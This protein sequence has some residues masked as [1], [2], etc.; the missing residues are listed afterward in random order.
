MVKFPKAAAVV[1]RSVEYPNLRSLNEVQLWREFDSWLRHEVV[2]K[3]IVS[4]TL[5][6]VKILAVPSVGQ[7]TE[8]S[9]LL[10][11]PKKSIFFRF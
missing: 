5:N 8:I 3:T 11:K 6:S 4:E 2:G 7:N 10:E 9:G 1:A